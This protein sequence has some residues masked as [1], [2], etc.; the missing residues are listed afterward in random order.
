MGVR[1]TVAL[2]ELTFTVGQV[3]DLPSQNASRRLALQ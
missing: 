3:F 2:P 1:Q